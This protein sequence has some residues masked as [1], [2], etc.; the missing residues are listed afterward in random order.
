VIKY[1]PF[2]VAVAS[3]LEFTLN[4]TSAAPVI[5]RVGSVAPN[6]RLAST[7]N[8]MVQLSLMRG[9]PVVLAFFCRCDP[10]HLVA[11]E[12]ARN[13]Q[14]AQ[15]ARIYAIFGDYTIGQPQDEKEFRE[16]T[17][18]TAPFLIDLASEVGLQYDS[19]H[20][21]RVWVIDKNGIVRYVNASQS[22]P[23]DQIVAGVLKAVTAAG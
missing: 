1:G 16:S 19:T 8:E 5:P 10:C 11:K 4:G 7:G 6:F 22:M 12:I 23:A 9:Q 21:P 18:F 14:L 3:G 20:C 17:G 13:P 2:P 15:R